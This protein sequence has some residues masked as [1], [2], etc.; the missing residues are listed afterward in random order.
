MIF[1]ETML[2]G[3]YIIDIEP[4]A[5]HRGFFARTWCQQEFEAHELNPNVVQT[6]IGYSHKRGTLRGMHYQTTPCAEVKLVRCSLGAMYDVI[7][8]LREDSPTYK[9]WIGL[10]LTQDNHRMLYVPE[11]FAH[12]YITL[13][14]NTEMSYQTTQF[15]SREHAT[16]VRYN[17][18]AFAIHWPIQIQIIS[19]QDKNWSDYTL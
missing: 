4:K 5:D 19:D 17:D 13:A 11:G 10:E 6:N 12:G 7:I 1:E 15:F 3:A 14:D 18:P 9:Q 8:D 16:G 2:K